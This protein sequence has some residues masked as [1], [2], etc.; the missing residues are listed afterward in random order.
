MNIAGF[1][2][3][4][5]VVLIAGIV[6]G[7]K[8]GIS[9]ELLDVLMWLGI[10]LVGAIG[11]KPL[12]GIL[13]SATNVPIMWAHIVAY[14]IIALLLFLLFGFIKRA[15]GA[16]LVES[17]T[18][19][20]FEYYLGMIAGAVRFLCVVIFLLSFLHA[21]YTTPAERAAQKKMQKDNFGD[22]TLPTIESL[23]ESIFV[24]SIAGKFL[25]KDIKWILIQ[26]VP[27]RGSTG[28]NIYENR[29]RTVEDA[30]K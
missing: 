3:F 30:M 5:A 15:V 19:G 27:P 8:R 26:P 25:D 7:R 13:A 1:D 2:L 12:G 28:T 24:E 16:K 21:K 18:F 14:I 6:R 9:E 11:Y 4:I 10:V 29:R 17:D 23:Q 20:R 22:I